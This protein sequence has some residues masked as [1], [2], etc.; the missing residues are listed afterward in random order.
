MPDPL[1]KQHVH[2]LLKERYEC[3]KEIRRL[4]NEISI[5][6]YKIRDIDENIENLTFDNVGEKE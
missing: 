6:E 1:W 4:R 5:L 3:N 2:N